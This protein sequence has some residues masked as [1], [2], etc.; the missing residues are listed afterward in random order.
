MPKFRFRLEAQDDSGHY[1]EGTG[2]FDSEA[3]ARA[4]LEQKE[5]GAAAYRLDTDELKE[6]EKAAKDAASNGVAAPGNVRAKLAL[7]RQAEPYKLVK[8][9]EVS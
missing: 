3:E 8:L 5:Q 6:A 9:E 7:H 4:Y 2:V 1:R